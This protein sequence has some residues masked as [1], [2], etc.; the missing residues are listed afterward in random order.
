MGCTTPVSSRGSAGSCLIYADVRL[1]IPMT[2]R[3]GRYFVVQGLICV[4][5][6][7][8]VRAIPTRSWKAI[9][10]VVKL[11]I[12]LA[13]GPWIG[14][15]WYLDKLSSCGYW[16]GLLELYPTVPLSAETLDSWVSPTVLQVVPREFAVHGAA[17]AAVLAWKRYYND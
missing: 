16:T 14:L 5:S 3:I 1:S 12:T 17:L 13:L 8:I 9:P 10:Q 6:T 2:H 11:Y 4:A 15:H 7:V